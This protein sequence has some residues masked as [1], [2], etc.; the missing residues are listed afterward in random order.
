[1]A[2]CDHCFA[3]CHDLCDNFD[4]LGVELCEIANAKY[5]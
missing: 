2:S 4:E 3:E 1:M 5:S